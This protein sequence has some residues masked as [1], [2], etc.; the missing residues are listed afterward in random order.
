MQSP[1][2]NIANSCAVCHRWSE[3][4]IRQRV[5]AIQDKVKAAVLAEEARISVARFLGAKGLAQG[6]DYPDYGTR[7]KALDLTEGL[8]HPGAGQRPAPQ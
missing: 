3:D 1:L 7:Q 4:Q 5:E 6:P 2:L 8:T